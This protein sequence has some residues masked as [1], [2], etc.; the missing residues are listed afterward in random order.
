MASVETYASIVEKERYGRD[1]RQAIADGL[2]FVAKYTKKV[3]KITIY[4]SDWFIYDT[5]IDGILN[6]NLYGANITVKGI[7]KDETIQLIKIQ[8]VGDTDKSVYEDYDIK[9]VAQDSNLLMFRTK[10]YKTEKPSVKIEIYVYTELLEPGVQG[11][12]SVEYAVEI[13]TELDPDSGLPVANRTLYEKFRSC[14]KKSFIQINNI[15]DIFDVMEG[16]TVDS[17]CLIKNMNI[18]QLNATLT[19]S[20]MDITAFENL[21]EFKQ[22]MTKYGRLRP[23]AFTLLPS[24]VYSSPELDEM[25]VGTITKVGNYY[26]SA[27]IRKNGGTCVLQLIFST[28]EDY[29][30]P[31]QGEWV[32]IATLPTGFKPPAE[33]RVMENN[34]NT[35]VVY[36]TQAAYVRITTSGE[37]QVNNI[38]DSRIGLRFVIPYVVSSSTVTPIM[39]ETNGTADGI[40]SNTNLKN[41]Q[42][43]KISAMWAIEEY[44]DY[45]FDNAIDVDISTILPDFVRD[46]V[47]FIIA[48]QNSEDGD[49]SPEPEPEPNN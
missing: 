16:L 33:V 39:L 34:V 9:C 27:S 45:A 18:V 2:R 3:L 30:R 23:S 4:P 29:T 22:E 8:P 5:K 1:V 14:Q 43:L 44:V 17:G 6:L 42:T 36:A 41:V 38:L 47:E 31:P 35:G 26:S 32:T 13:D 24:V 19:A 25:V 37:V 11:K 15:T 12:N 21:L 49:P 40:F 7:M 28:S 10:A 48:E 46:D 20:T